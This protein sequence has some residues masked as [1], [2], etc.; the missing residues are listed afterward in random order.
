MG[1]LV[2]LL[3]DFRGFSIWNFSS[4]LCTDDDGIMWEKRQIQFIFIQKGWLSVFNTSTF[5]HCFYPFIFLQNSSNGTLRMER[6]GGKGKGWINRVNVS[7]TL[8]L[9][10]FS[11]GTLLSVKKK[12]AEISLTS[13]LFYWILSFRRDFLWQFLSQPLFSPLDFSFEQK[14][15]SSIYF[16]LAFL[17]FSFFCFF[18]FKS[19]FFTNDST[20]KWV[21]GLFCGDFLLEFVLTL[22]LF[23]TFRVEKIE[24]FSHPADIS[25]TLCPLSL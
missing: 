6:R 4:V 11:W 21:C 22:F 15:I 23:S 8:A 18:T 14:K 5:S 16:F 25:A 12:K 3:E 13:L 20:P 1:G 2:L 17:K 10:L 7:L 24:K 19:V 9:F